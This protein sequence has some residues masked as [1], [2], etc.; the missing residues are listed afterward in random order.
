MY[1]QLPAT[2]DS[3]ITQTRGSAL[4]TIRLVSIVGLLAVLSGCTGVAREP[5]SIRIVAS[6]NVYGSIAKAIAGDRAEVTSII[7]KTGQDPH[8]FE[9]SARVRLELDRANLVIENGGGYD[10]FIDNL[11]KAGKVRDRRVINV[12]DLAV[13][14]GESSSP[15]FNEHLWYDLEVMKLLVARI[16]LSLTS[17]DPAGAQYFADRSSKLLTALEELDSRVRSF[18][19]EEWGGRVI[20]TEPVS[21]RLLDAMG[22]EDLTPVSVGH[23]LEEGLGVPIRELSR[24]LNL[25]GDHDADAL[26]VNTQTYGPEVGL[27]IEKAEEVG[28]PVI[29][30]GELL[31]ES[32]E[33]YIEWIGKTIGELESAVK[34]GSK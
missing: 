32:A 2:T 14:P 9:A 5:E 15:D 19:R 29:D 24:L 12:V 27:L 20:S 13:E 33:G 30:V 17:L 16:E 21:G 18:S 10:D 23:E 11:L 1:N 4:K 31:P 6:T 3:P 7:Y 28:T 26:V 34:Q 25:L 22:I 8:S